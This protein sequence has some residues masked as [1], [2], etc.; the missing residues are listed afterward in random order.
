MWQGSLQRTPFSSLQPQKPNA[1]SCFILLSFITNL[2]KMSFRFY[3]GSSGSWPPTYHE[4]PS[5]A[6]PQYRSLAPSISPSDSYSRG[7]SIS[8][9]QSF[10]RAPS[11]NSFDSYSQAPSLSP[12]R[13]YSRSHSIAPPRS[14]SQASCRR[15]S[16]TPSHAGP[17]IAVF[18]G[19]IGQIQ[20]FLPRYLNIQPNVDKFWHFKSLSL[21]DLLDKAEAKTGECIELLVELHRRA[22][23]HVRNLSF[24]RLPLTTTGKSQVCSLN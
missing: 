11:I 18:P 1:Y 16:R 24:P 10:S 20:P 2:P 3:A 9:P 4:A 7:P 21:H 14:Y 12:P 15:H 8:L 23:T 5:I 19:L 22:S 6:P 13:S 17:R